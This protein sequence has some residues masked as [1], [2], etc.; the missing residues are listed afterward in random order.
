MR[1]PSWFE[2]IAAVFYPIV[3]ILLVVIAPILTTVTMAN[4]VRLLKLFCRSIRLLERTV[5][6][7]WAMAYLITH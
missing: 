5:T 6:A 1:L 4:I 3:E 2:P 7:N